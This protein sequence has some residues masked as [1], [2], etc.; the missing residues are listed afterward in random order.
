MTHI[1]AGVIAREVA[2]VE[3]ASLMP[4]NGFEEVCRKLII[5]R[6]ILQDHQ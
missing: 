5:E 3:I 1:T 2:L 4:E 6:F